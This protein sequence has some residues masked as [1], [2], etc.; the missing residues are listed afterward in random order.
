MACRYG[1]IAVELGPEVVSGEGAA[2]HLAEHFATLAE[3]VEI[4]LTSGGDDF[5]GRGDAGDVPARVPPG[6]LVSRGEVE[7]AEAVELSE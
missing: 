6:I 2:D 7:A 5:N 4:D 3:G 1:G